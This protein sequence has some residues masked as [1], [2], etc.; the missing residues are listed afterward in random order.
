MRAYGSLRAIKN[1]CFLREIFAY[2]T[3]AHIDPRGLDAAAPVA[4]IELGSARRRQ[5]G[6]GARPQKTGNIKDILTRNTTGRMKKIDMCASVFFGIEG[7]LHR[8]RP[9]VTAPHQ[10]RH[11]MTML[12]PQF[13]LGMPT[14][15]H[16]CLPPLRSRRFRCVIDV[17]Q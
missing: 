11:F 1:D 8:E 6:F 2:A 10:A 9:N 12:E 17:E 7:L 15:A 4:A 5:D 13:K 3:L 14:L 16:E